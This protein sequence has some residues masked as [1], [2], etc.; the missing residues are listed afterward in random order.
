VEAD[1]EQ[2][3]DSRGS[4]SCECGDSDRNALYKSVLA[5]RLPPNG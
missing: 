3:D 5:A 4:H 2:N 1:V